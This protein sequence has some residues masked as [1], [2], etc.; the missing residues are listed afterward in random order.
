MRLEKGPLFHALNA[1]IDLTN[2]YIIV[3][4]LVGYIL[5]DID[6]YESIQKY[7]SANCI[8]IS[9]FVQQKLKELDI[10]SYLIPASIPKIYQMSGYLDISHVALFIPLR[11]DSYIIDGS[12][13]FLTPIKVNLGENTC[14]D[15]IFSKKNI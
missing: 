3:G 9:F 13:Y 6:S 1:H 5:D 11:G 15:T 2:Y 14:I 12:F 10:I 4:S 8:G 7:N